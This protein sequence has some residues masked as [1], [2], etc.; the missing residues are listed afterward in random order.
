MRFSL[1]FLFLVHSLC[2][3][4]HGEVMMFL[5]LEEKRGW[6]IVR[7]ER[8]RCRIISTSLEV[9]TF[10]CMSESKTCVYVA[11]DGSLRIVDSKTE[12]TLLE[13]GKDGYTQP[14]FSK[15]GTRIWLV[16]LRNGNSKK[17]EIGWIDPRRPSRFHTVLQRHSTDLDPWLGHEG[18]FYYAHVS[19]AEG[20]GRIIQEIWFHG[21]AGHSRQLTLENRLAHQPSFDPV[22]QTLYYSVYTLEG[23]RIRKLHLADSSCRGHTIDERPDVSDAW[24]APDGK[25]GLYF[26]RTGR[27]RDSIVHC[28]DTGSCHPLMLRPDFSTIRNLK[29]NP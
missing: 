9:Q 12:K 17:T 27:T 1:L 19:C 23:Y 16:R 25:G 24:P 22:H 21:P 15:D 13:K 3:Y 11:S 20:C 6:Q 14:R 8:E 28:D 26:V 7:C 18:G 10:D 5:T 4:E 2:A 29:V